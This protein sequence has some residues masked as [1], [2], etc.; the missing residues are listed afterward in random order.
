MAYTGLKRQ[1][2]CP[3]SQLACQLQPTAQ[4]S[5]TTN[6]RNSTEYHH[7]D[8][9]IVGTFGAPLNMSP[10]IRGFQDNVTSWMSSLVNQQ[11]GCLQMVARQ[12]SV[13]KLRQEQLAR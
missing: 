7:L 3:E 4:E 9:E 13:G 2:E 5:K 1:E 11:D 8:T 10:F 12:A 6:S